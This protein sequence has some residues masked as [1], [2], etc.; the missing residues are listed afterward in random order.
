MFIL[1][2]FFKFIYV[3]GLGNFVFQ[4]TFVSGKIFVDEI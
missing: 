4:T 3:G 2:F 1:L